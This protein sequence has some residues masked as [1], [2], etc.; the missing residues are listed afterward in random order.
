MCEIFPK[1][2]GPVAPLFL[3]KMYP[4]QRVGELNLRYVWDY[5]VEYTHKSML[6]WQ[7]CLLNWVST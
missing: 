6:V 5:N 2:S 3:E 4:R 7:V 1:H